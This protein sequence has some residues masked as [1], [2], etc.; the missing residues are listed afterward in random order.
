ML[1]KPLLRDELT[2]RLREFVLE[3]QSDTAV[4]IAPERQLAEMHGVS[5]LSV[6]TALK[7]LVVEGLLTQRQGSGTYIVPV[8]STT[9]IRILMASD[10]KQTDP[11]FNEFLATITHYC[12]DHKIQLQVGRE[13]LIDLRSVA[14]MPLVIVGL[15]QDGTIKT[16]KDTQG[17]VIS[18]QFYPDFLEITQVYFDDGR[19]GWEAAEIMHANGHRRVVLL[20]GPS[21]YRSAHE[22][23]Q[24]FSQAATERGM[25][26][27]VLRG[28]MNWRSGYELGDR[29]V[30]LLGRAD[31][32]TGVFASNDGMALGLMHRLAEERIPI[33]EAISIIG[34]DDIHMAS[35]IAPA[36]STFRWN[37]DLLVR[38]LVNIIGAEQTRS[39]Q[40]HKRVLLPARFVMRETV[41]V[42]SD[43]K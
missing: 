11:F 35:E 41:G 16:I 3:Q 1:T 40:T 27:E 32:P 12:T 28:K 29:V 5:R 24:G 18:T 4:R 14:P 9:S 25:N 17:L 38:E 20:A 37:M 22:R 26:V 13:G 31:P 6:R 19:I 34:C 8:S 33:P 42:P 10:I 15:V 43:Q 23:A 39:S 2:S 7:A 30:E 21:A 36:L